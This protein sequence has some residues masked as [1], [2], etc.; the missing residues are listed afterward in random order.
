LFYGRTNDDDYYE[1][2]FMLTANAEFVLKVSVF[3]SRTARLNR[4]KWASQANPVT[5]TPTCTM[6]RWRVKVF[7]L[8]GNKHKLRVMEDARGRVQVVGL[9][10]EAVSSVDDVTRLV[11]RGSVLRTSG[12]TSANAHSS[13]SHSVFQV[14]L[15]KK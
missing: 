9:R 10:E 12:T 11:Q 3:A 1:E 2:S 5:V 6:T 7:D 4:F 13:R 8:L 14:I 15:R